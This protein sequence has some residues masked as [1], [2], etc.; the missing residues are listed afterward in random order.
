MLSMKVINF[1]TKHQEE[2]ENL[3]TDTIELACCQFVLKTLLM[4]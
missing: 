3:L 1:L 4:K 2:V